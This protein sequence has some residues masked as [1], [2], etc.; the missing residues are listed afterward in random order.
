[1]ASGRNGAT[2]NRMPPTIPSKQTM[3][4]TLRYHT[5]NAQT[6]W[7]RQVEEQ[8]ERLHRLVPITAA[9][10]ELEHQQQIKPPFHV[11]IR[12]EMPGPRPDAQATRHTRE[13]A[14]RVHGPDLHAE[15]RDH[16]L[17]AALLKA[18]KNLE[19]QVQSIQKRRKACGRSKLQL[20][21]VSGRW[22][23]QQPT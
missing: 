8:I 3:K 20:S 6:G 21:A 22:H 12:L 2:V 13:G 9:E 1:M 10:V 7:H 23:H 16:T 14:L 5:L 19:H 18:V 17:A 11:Q 4:T 15:G